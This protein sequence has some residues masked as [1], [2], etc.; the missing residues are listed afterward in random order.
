MNLSSVFCPR[1]LPFP[2]VN[3]LNSFEPLH[4]LQQMICPVTGTAVPSNHGVNLLKPWENYTFPPLWLFTPSIL[5][6]QKKTNTYWQHNT[7]GH[8]IFPEKLYFIWS[9][10]SFPHNYWVIEALGAI[11][12][13]PL[14]LVFNNHKA[15]TGHYTLTQ[16]FGLLQKLLDNRFY[17]LNLGLK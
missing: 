12:T 5:P 14:F 3:D 6:K 11:C 8:C 9:F 4:A 17:I 7:I 13:F 10:F 16:C 2:S 1:R 15:I